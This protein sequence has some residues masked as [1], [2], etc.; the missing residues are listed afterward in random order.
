VATSNYYAYRE[1]YYFAFERGLGSN[2]HL[3]NSSMRRCRNWRIFCSRFWIR[4]KDMTKGSSP[5]DAHIAELV[6]KFKMAVLDANEIPPQAKIDMADDGPVLLAHAGDKIV[7]QTNFFSF[8]VAGKQYTAPAT[9]VQRL[10]RVR[11]DHAEGTNDL[12][13]RGVHFVDE[14]SCMVD[15]TELNDEMYHWGHQVYMV[16]YNDDA[17]PEFNVII[18]VS[19]FGENGHWEVRD[20]VAG[21]EIDNRYVNVRGLRNSPEVV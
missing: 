15:D 4:N 19:R 6:T 2:S 14:F 12:V 8:V 17:H 7:K 18:H 10:Q 11:V 21:V 3:S 16:S 9:T 5:R 13:V 20:Y 1:F